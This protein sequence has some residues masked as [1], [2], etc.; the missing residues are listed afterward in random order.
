MAWGG[1]ATTDN[2]GSRDYAFP[3]RTALVCPAGDAA[4]LAAHV[5]TLL[6]DPELRHRLAR[7]GRE[8][9]A[10][11]SWDQA[12]ADLEACLVRYL[13]DPEAYQHEPAADPRRAPGR[14]ALR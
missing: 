3:D 10:G 13:A 7:A 12:G 1:L 6:G 11:F 5:A 9:V 8:L 2:G 4:A 14:F